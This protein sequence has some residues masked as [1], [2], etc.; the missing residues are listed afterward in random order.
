M[1]TRK[2]VKKAAV[3]KP[4]PRVR[5]ASAAKSAPRATDA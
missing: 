5:K 2:S 1:A 3:R 4:A